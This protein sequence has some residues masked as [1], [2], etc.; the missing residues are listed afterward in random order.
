MRPGLFKT[1]SVV[2]PSSKMPVE[3]TAGIDTGSAYTLLVRLRPTNAGGNGVFIGDAQVGVNNGYLLS[4]DS[5]MSDN[6]SMN[7]QVTL[8]LAAGDTV[9]AAQFT[10][11]QQIV[12]IAAYSE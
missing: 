9:W 10:G 4:N 3:L 8:K 12:D 11:V 1:R 5:S 7:P 6:I 2:I